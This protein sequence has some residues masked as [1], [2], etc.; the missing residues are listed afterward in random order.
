VR[1]RLRSSLPGGLF[2]LKTPVATTLCSVPRRAVMGRPSRNRCVVFTG[3][4]VVADSGRVSSIRRLRVAYLAGFACAAILVGV[5]VL[6]MTRLDLSGSGDGT[7]ERALKSPC[8]VDQRAPGCNQPPVHPRQRSRPRF[9]V[10]P[11]PVPVP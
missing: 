2:H 3:R 1:R 8:A 5:A 11:V 7:A 9:T 4:A 6:A 10:R